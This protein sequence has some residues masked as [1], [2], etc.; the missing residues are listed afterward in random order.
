MSASK[1]KKIRKQ[2]RAAADWVDAKAVR[3]EQERKAQKRS[4]LIFSVVAVLFVAVAVVSLVW[5]S[6]ILQKNA[7]ALTINGESYS[8]AEVQYYYT[9]SYRSFL[10]ENYDYLSFFGLDMNSSLKTQECFLLEDGTWH[11]YFLEDAAKTMQDVQALNAAAAK[12]AAFQWND[13]MQA[14]YDEYM[15]TMEAAR[16]DYNETYSAN[17]E[18][19]PYIQL[20]YGPLMTKDVYEAETRRTIIA[21]T[22]SND[23]ADSLEYSDSE[24]DQHYAENKKTYDQVSYESI[25]VSGAAATKDAD[26][27]D[28]TPTDADK[29]AAMAEAKKLA[30]QLLEEYENGAALSALGEEHEDEASLTTT[31]TGTWSDSVLNNWLFDE[32]RAAGDFAL[33]EDTDGSAYYVVEFKARARQEYNT[34]N[35]RHILIPFGT[36]DKVEGDEGYEEQQKL[37]DEAAKAQAQDILTEWKNGAATE[38]SFAELAK[39]NSTDT[40]SASNGG[41]YEN[42][43]KGAMVPEFEDWCFAE[44]RAAGDTGLVASDY[45]YHVM[46][47]VGEDMPYW[48]MQVSNSMMSDD[49]TEWYN[50]IVEGY[51]HELHSFGSSIVG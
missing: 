25:R 37:L 21:Q 35:V 2:Q 31:E 18:V 12:D 26:G 50:G 32:S 19:E 41:L 1:E 16:A 27:N 15:A 30:E 7:S 49:Y 3:Q 34:V 42:V 22:F 48:K 51:S 10:N 40:G 43:Y 28:I 45:G 36:G 33:L 5:N 13:A 46:Y 23:Y 39:E 4:N 20:V 8:P 24:I 17:L 47:F 14:E 44:G 38:E 29:A 9:N 11:D 6:G